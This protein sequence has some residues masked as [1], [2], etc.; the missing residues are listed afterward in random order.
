MRYRHSQVLQLAGISKDAI[1]HW[2][3]HLGPLRHKDGRSQTYTFSEIVA[4]AAIADAVKV[5]GL[6]VER[7]A[8]MADRLFALVAKATEPDRSP[9]NL[10]VGPEN[11]A[12]EA[13]IPQTTA[14][15]ILILPLGPII[16]RIRNRITMIDTPDAP[17]TQYELPIP[18]QRVVGLPRKRSSY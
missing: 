3:L 10:L 18:G 17:P 14:N 16:V 2:K 13:E 9:G 15:C 4:I 1:R 11:V 6:S 7:L 12:W 5:F 8:P